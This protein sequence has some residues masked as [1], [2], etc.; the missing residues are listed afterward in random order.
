[1]IALRRKRKEQPDLNTVQKPVNIWKLAMTAMLSAIAFLL[2]FLEFSV[3]VMPPFIKMDFSELPALL[4]AFAVGPV[5]GVMICL[6]KNLMHLLMS[7]SGGVGEL[8]NFLLGACFVFPA[9]LV[10][11]KW[12]GKK[13]AVLGASAGAALMAAVSIFSNYFIVYPFYYNFMSKEAVLQAYQAIL[14]GVKN[15]LECLIVFNAP[16]TL[17]KGLLCVAATTF[18][19]KPLSPFLKGSVRNR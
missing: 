5:S 18:I 6:I 1:M 7:T 19:Y 16:F 10:Y 3:P 12:K 9:G 8:S 13:S 15:I 17:V 2:M 14:P 11:Q 4:G